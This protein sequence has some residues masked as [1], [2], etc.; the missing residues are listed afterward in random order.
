MRLP[1]K[2]TPRL[3]KRE[4]VGKTWRAVRRQNGRFRQVGRH[5]E[6]QQKVENKLKLKVKLPT[7]G[8]KLSTI[9]NEL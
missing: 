4:H 5:A 6:V 1:S 7:I 3:C 9:D 2:T 8:K